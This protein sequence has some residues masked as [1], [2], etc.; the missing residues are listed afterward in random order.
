MTLAGWSPTEESSQIRSSLTT[1]VNEHVAAGSAAR[2]SASRVAT[3][4]VAPFTGFEVPH[5][6]VTPSVCFRLRRC[7]VPPAEV[8]V[9]PAA[10]SV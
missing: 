7:Q 3:T 2:R 10:T 9:A 8:P 4:N 6:L 5:S 1:S